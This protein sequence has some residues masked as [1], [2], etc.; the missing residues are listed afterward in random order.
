[1]LQIFS[2]MF[3]I[4]F[5]I[6]LGL[7]AVRSGLA[8]QAQ[9]EGLGGFVI[10]FAL[11]AVILSALAHQD[12]GH[13]I[14]PG[15]LAAYALGSLAAFAAVFLFI[16]FGLG[17]PLERAGMGALGAAGS[18]T[19]F[20]GFPIAALVL[21]APATIAMPMTMIVENML[22]IPLGL[23]L[24]EMG[25]SNGAS[26]RR[27]LGETAMRLLRMP[28]VI[29]IIAGAVLSVLGVRFP[30]PLASSIDLLGQASAP[31]ALFVVGGTIAALRR[32]D[33]GM[34]IAPI[35]LGK[36]VLH[37]LAVTGAFLLV[38]GVPPELAATGIL[39]SSVSMLT[40]YPI[41]ARRAGMENTAAAALIIAT[42]LCL[43]TTAAVLAFVLDRFGPAIGT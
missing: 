26:L 42:V 37:P 27:M 22:I 3:P 7:V 2:L 6:G 43:V 1:M 35:V 14:S 15:Y 32:G 20:I 21:G 17:R 16:R 19:G 40:I 9:I 10:N 13:S 41:F 23:A 29:A 28:F 36:L 5:L 34:E 4:L 38:P 12:L 18:D 31:V 11:P 30:V 33:L 24:A 8:S 39:F 25:T